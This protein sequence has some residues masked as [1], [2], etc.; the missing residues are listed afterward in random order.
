MNDGMNVCFINMPIEYY[1]PA[2][3]GA[4]STVIMEMATQLIEHGHAVS[5]ITPRDTNGLYEV[6]EVHTFEMPTREEATLFRRQLSKWV[7]RWN[8]YSWQF[9]DVFVNRVLRAI[10]QLRTTPDFFITQNDLVLADILRR[11]FPRGAIISWLHNE[12]SSGYSRG[13]AALQS[14]DRFI[15]VSACIRDWTVNKHGIAPEKVTVIH[16][17]V[18]LTAFHPR[19]GY[20]KHGIP[21][22]VLFI[23]RID[24]NKGPDL[25]ADAVTALQKEGIDVR[26]TVAGGLWFYGE[27]DPMTD[28]FF[29]VLHGKM[30][31]AAATYLGHV[32][33]PDVPQ[34]IREHDVVCVLSRSNEPFGLVALEAMA[35]GCAV[36]ASNRG[37]LP[38][39]CGEAATL[40]DP[41]A[42]TNSIRRLAIDSHF[43]AEQKRR[44]V[45]RAAKSGWDVSAGRLMEAL[46]DC[47]R[48]E[49]GVG[50][51]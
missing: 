36:I 27:T 20:L 48:A 37:G 25:V 33:R 9:Y 28:P 49:T 14:T 40:V 38:E 22:K 39:A 30:V 16:N 12:V 11:A 45:A 35:S 44:S 17:G 41:D 21:P 31:V 32:A 24:P 8:G 2:S 4:V 26:L 7:G 29:R 19:A 51:P 34:L 46:G 50:T 10:R 6:G 3:G 1:S 47:R 43:L 42:V 13:S 18:N 5:V 15:A 23:G